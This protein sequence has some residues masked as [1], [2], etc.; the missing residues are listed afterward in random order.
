MGQHNKTNASLKFKKVEFEI[1][2]T[3][4]M[5]I[6]FCDAILC[7]LLDRYQ[8]FRRTYCLHF[9]DKRVLLSCRRRQQASYHPPT[10]YHI[11]KDCTID[12]NCFFSGNRQKNKINKNSK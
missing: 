3:E 9:Q 12:T 8:C 5:N 7:N 11:P 10:W 1:L 2:K 6:V 4:G